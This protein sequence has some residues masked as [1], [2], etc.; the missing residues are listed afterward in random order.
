[1]GKP[2]KQTNKNLVDIIFPFFGKLLAFYSNE[3]DTN[4]LVFDL[5][6]NIA[7]LRL[8]QLIFF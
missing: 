5:D 2:K 1:M 7:C 6:K 4:I 3:Y 8:L